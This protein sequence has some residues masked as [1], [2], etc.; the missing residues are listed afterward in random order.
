L[1]NKH[2][3]KNTLLSL[4]LHSNE[5]EGIS[6]QNVGEWALEPFANEPIGDLEDS[7]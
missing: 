6:T 2:H 5:I 4:C 3:I 7:S 1:L